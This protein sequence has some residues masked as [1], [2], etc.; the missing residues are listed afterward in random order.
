[1]RRRD[2]SGVRVAVHLGV[3]PELALVQCPTTFDTFEVSLGPGAVVRP[4]RRVS[5]GAA[6]R[7]VQQLTAPTIAPLRLLAQAQLQQAIIDA[8]GRTDATDPLRFNL[9]FPYVWLLALCRDRM[10]R[11]CEDHDILTMVFKDDA[12]FNGIVGFEAWPAPTSKSR[13]GMQRVR[14]AHPMPPRAPPPLPCP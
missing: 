4:L 10:Q 7:A 11:S 12:E 1:M 9:A 5:E 3:A 2:I 8:A 6:V 13:W 14:A